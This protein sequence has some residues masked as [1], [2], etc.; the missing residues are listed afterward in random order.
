MVI[1]QSGAKASSQLHSSELEIRKASMQMDT[2]TSLWSD[3]PFTSLCILQTEKPNLDTT[4]GSRIRSIFVKTE[5]WQASSP[6]PWFVETWRSSLCWLAASSEECPPPSF[7]TGS[8]RSML[9][10]HRRHFLWRGWLI[11]SEEKKRRTSAHKRCLE[12]SDFQWWWD[13]QDL[14]LGPFFRLWCHFHHRF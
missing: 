4:A 6:W 2:R 13:P 9:S 7:S 3:R 11:L 8:P 10:W 1:M 5:S 12:T 14:E